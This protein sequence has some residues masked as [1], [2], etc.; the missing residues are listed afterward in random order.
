MSFKIT[1]NEKEINKSIE[2]AIKKTFCDSLSSDADKILCCV[3][4]EYLERRKSGL[5]KVDAQRFNE[6]FYLSD[7]KLSKWNPKDISFTLLELGQCGY[8]RMYI[9]GEFDLETKAITYMEGRFKNGLSEIMDF[10]SKFIS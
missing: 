4:K 6:D 5:A 2:N 7:R 3:Y 9:G 8:I 1:I 10:I